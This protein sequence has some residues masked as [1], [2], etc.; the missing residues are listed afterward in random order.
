MWHEL[1]LNGVGGRTIAEAKERISLA[2]FNRWVEYFQRR[3]SMSTP[4]RLESGFALIASL[5]CR[6]TGNESSPEDFMP[7]REEPEL[8]LEQAMREWK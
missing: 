3:G 2:E 6:A 1:V 5:I 4:N 7:H 8:T